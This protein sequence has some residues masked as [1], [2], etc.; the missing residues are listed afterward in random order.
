MCVVLER[1]RSLKVPAFHC[2]FVKIVW[3]RL[4]FRVGFHRSLMS[5]WEDEQIWAGADPA[6]DWPGF[7]LGVIFGNFFSC[8]YMIR[9]FCL[10]KQNLIFA[11]HKERRR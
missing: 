11:V 1:E 4:L 9:V 3:K 10:T 7:K 8:T 2:R 5:V 6:R